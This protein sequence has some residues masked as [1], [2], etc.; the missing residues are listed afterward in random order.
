[1]HK[2]NLMFIRL[3][4]SD[5]TDLNL[6]AQN[7]DDFQPVAEGGSVVTMT[8]GC[9]HNVQESCV[10]IRNRFKKLGSED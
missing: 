7:I 2:E 8:S 6:V 1:M 5:G 3:K 9:I 4:N 10:S